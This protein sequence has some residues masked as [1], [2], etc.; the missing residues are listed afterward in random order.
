MPRRARLPL[1]AAS[2]AALLSG[3]AGCNN[4]GNGESSTTN[5]VK[6]SPS[7]G[8]SVSTSPGPRTSGEVVS[9]SGGPG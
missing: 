1:A 7:G 3:L 6:K 8:A 9:P 2:L 5:D 4:S